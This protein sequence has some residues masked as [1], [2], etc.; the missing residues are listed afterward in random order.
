MGIFF[1]LISLYKYFNTYHYYDFYIHEWV[2][3]IIYA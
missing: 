3:G 2:A 1:L